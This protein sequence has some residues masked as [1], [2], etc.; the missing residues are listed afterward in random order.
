[1]WKK[2]FVLALLASVVPGDARGPIDQEPVMAGVRLFF[3]PRPGFEEVDTDLTG[4]ARRTLDIAAYV[5][6]DKRIIAALEAAVKRGVKVRLY[7]DP[8][9][10][11]GRAGLSAR[12]AQL[13]RGSGVEARIKG[14][15]ADYMHM[16]A[17]QVDGRYLRSGSANFSFS[18]EHR[19]DNDIIVIESRAAA[20][21][22]TQQ[23]EQLWARAG[24]V[25]FAP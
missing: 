1:M 9:Q 19:Q 7:L 13:L 10:P 14:I 4:R 18:G 20:G 5:L 12:F 24:N 11:G 22:F 17:Y 15:G 2:L 25:P 3:G 16:K 23:F 6:T 8:E 21:A